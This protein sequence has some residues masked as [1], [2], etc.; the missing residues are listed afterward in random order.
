[1]KNVTLL[2]T[3]FTL[4]MTTQTI[5]AN[6]FSCYGEA[7]GIFKSADLIDAEVFVEA[8]LK[9]EDQLVGQQVCVVAE[10]MKRLGDS[11]ASEY[12]EKAIA[13]DPTEPGWELWYANYITQ[14]RG[15]MVPL[16]E[17]GK[18]H[19][20][21]A[22]TK[23]RNK[24]GGSLDSLSEVDANLF[25]WI[26]RG[27][28]K[29]YQEDGIALTPWT[30]SI[31]NKH[32]D[33]SDYMLPNL[34]ITYIDRFT[35]GLSE[36][37][38]PDYARSRASEALWVRD[39][40]WRDTLTQQDLERIA[41][42]NN[43]SDIH[44]R[45]I[46]TRLRHPIISIDAYIKQVSITNGMVSS[47]M[48]LNSTAPSDKLNNWHDFNTITSQDYGLLLHRSFDFYPLFD[49]YWEAGV[50]SQMNKG[51]IEWFPESKG[52]TMQFDTKMKL[53]RFIGP[54]KLQLELFYMNQNIQDYTYP[55]S[56]NWQPDAQKHITPGVTLE[57]DRYMAGIKVDY[58]LYTPIR[59]PFK[60]KAQYT[61]GWHWYTGI[62]FDSERWWAVDDGILQRATKEVKQLINNGDMALQQTL[63]S[64]EESKNYRDS[65]QTVITNSLDSSRS[66]VQNT[67]VYVGTNLK[68]IGNFDLQLQY[69]F[70][71]TKPYVEDYALW[72][73]K[74]ALQYNQIFGHVLYRII[75]E[76]VVPGMP[77][78]SLI[79]PVF[80]QLGFPLSYDFAINGPQGYENK[81]DTF[82]A[83]GEVQM[84]FL[85]NPLGTYIIFTVGGG[86]QYYNHLDTG[87][88]L[89]SG[90]VNMG[91]KF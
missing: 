29:M 26:Q 22:I 58:A 89:Y 32:L 21:N 51:F 47:A 79:S 14:V 31:R 72:S 63:D 3:L 11:R 33:V 59:F 10:L 12:Y 52:Y 87:F 24:Y 69:T 75:D 46:R 36:F 28:S 18:C 68:G 1:M 77:Q 30:W 50:T 74:D 2:L 61:R 7:E 34:F 6:S 5:F 54:N 41:T 64:L 48:L 67:D 83:Q 60:K 9:I 13:L 35:H 20:L 42:H 38:K 19:Y 73:N 55:T 82:K 91:W 85:I 70:F 71:Y 88:A 78:Y 25:S 53:S 86:Y 43:G 23:L 49:L 80:L 65:I 44:T 84:K 4:T 37:D 90:S 27:Y 39:A 16:R 15:P 66:I 17:K 62:M 40:L 76:D 81:F 56:V 8:Q 45:L 57:R